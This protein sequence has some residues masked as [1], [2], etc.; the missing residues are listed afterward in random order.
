MDR[1]RK[2]DSLEMTATP[3]IEKRIFVVR[4]RQVMLDE[5]LADLYGV[6][7]KRLIEQVK[8]NLERFPA[9]FMFQLR[10]DEAAALRSQIATSNAG[11]G[12]RR[13]APYVFTEQGVAM[14]SSVLR[15]KTAI[16]VNIEIMRAF[17]ELR[18]VANSY[19]AIEKRLEQIDEGWA[20]TMSNWSRSSAPFVS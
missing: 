5:D 11:R 9:D 3:V 1:E 2:A 4:E 12:G 17:V 10:K 6:E 8:R 13:Y 19:A 20:S 16:A 18:R 15:S 7:T 14:L